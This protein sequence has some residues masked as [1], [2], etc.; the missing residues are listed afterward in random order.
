M[1][2]G[3]MFI[4]LKVP[5]LTRHSA[6]VSVRLS[7][8]LTL[9][10]IA[11]G[12]L[13]AVGPS[14]FEAV[15][16]PKKEEAV[17]ID[18]PRQYGERYKLKT[19]RSELR[20]ESIDPKKFLFAK[21]AFLEEKRDEAIR[22][23]RQQLDA[24][25]P[26]NRPNLLLSL[27]QLYAEKYMDLSYRETELYTE[28]LGEY[29]KQKEKDKKAKAPQLDNARSKRYLKDALGLFYSLEREHPQH[30]KIDE[31]LFFIGFVEIESGNGDK[32]SRYLERVVREFQRSRKYDEAVIYLADYYFDKSRFADALS[33]YRIL[34]GRRDSELQPYAFYKMAWCELNTNRASQALRN[35]RKLIDELDG[36]SDKGKFNLR[37]QAIKDLAVFFVE[38]DAV[39][40]A[41]EF[42]K[43]KEGE[44][45]A[46]ENLKLIADMLRSKARDTAAIKAYRLIL[47]ERPEHPEAP[48][49]ELGIYESLARMGRANDAVKALN[50][51]IAKYNPTSE[52]MSGYK[53]TAEEKK[54]V[55]DAIADEGKRAGFFYH[56]AAQK[57]KDKGLY[58]HALSLYA[59]LME[60]YPSHP[61]RKKIQFFRAE[62]LYA[63]SKWLEAAN[64][65]IEVSKTIPKDKLN[66]EA[67]YNALL[68]LDH[69]TAKSG[70]IERYKPEQQKDVD[71]SPQD[72]PEGE[73]RFIEVAQ[74]YLKEFP[75]GK[76]SL[77]VRYRIGAIH[78][79]YKHFE[80]ALKEFEALALQH[81]SDKVAPF[82]A[83]L[84][85][86]IYNMRKNYEG[87]ELAAEKYLKIGS[88]GDAKFKADMREVG[89]E[90]G[91]KKIEKLEANQEWDKAGDAYWR[92]YQ[93]NPKGELAEKSLYNAHVSYTKSQKKQRADEV[94]KVFL[95]QFPKSVHS[96]DFA[97]AAAKAAEERFDFQQA[98]QLFEKFH[99][100]HPKHKEARKALF[101]AALFAELLG[102]AKEAKDLYGQYLRSGT[103]P[104]EERQA[105]E[106]SL[107]AIHKKLKDLNEMEKMFRSLVRDAK[108]TKDKLGYLAELAKQFELAGQAKDRERLVREIASMYES[109]AESARKDF[110]PALEYVAEARFLA[111]RAEKA[112][113]EKIELRFPPQD[114]VYLLGRKQKALKNFAAKL[115][116]VIEVGVPLW[117][118]AALFDKSDAYRHFS[119]KYSE[120]QI[121]KKY[122]EAER[123][124]ADA[125]LKQIEKDLV[126]PL[127]VKGREFALSCLEK[128]REFHVASDYVRQCGMVASLETPTPSGNTPKAGHFSYRIPLKGFTTRWE[129]KAPEPKDV[130]NYLAYL[131][132]IDS[133]NRSQEV[134][135]RLTAFMAENPKDLRAQFIF[136]NHSWRTGNRE[137]ARFFYSKLEKEPEFEWRSL[138]LNQYG[139]I[140]LEE[141]RPVVAADWFEK[142]MESQPQ[143]APVFV[144]LGSM[145]LESG[146]YRDAEVLFLRATKMDSAWEDAAVGLGSAL[147]GQGK[148]QEAAETYAE[149]LSDNSDAL[150]AL[151]NHALILGNRLNQ[152]VKASQLMLQYLQKGGK[153]TVRAQKILGTW[154]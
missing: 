143:Y 92:A 105:I 36:A 67:L 32:G 14:S 64:A 33:K 28:R 7:T 68:A 88:L 154:R 116:K 60:H 15:S 27:G 137:M 113:Y 71:L 17:A 10:Q 146:N 107:L 101:N 52:W 18:V 45:K 120:V 118:V 130:D 135:K 122:S 96:A 59:S 145:Y 119:Q 58:R 23:M 61:E 80:E 42:Y 108:T 115:D 39:D 62:I 141:K 4:R 3:P 111:L 66:D 93:T 86:D 5:A 75:K 25:L 124:E 30:P 44:D 104:E 37:E 151:Y 43:D 133:V 72:I 26:G 121:P 74:L 131:A 31:V 65:Y 109:S 35:M 38:A 144:N 147:E 85:L 117:G 13:Y 140:A 16:L 20:Q 83:Y 6:L 79:K 40:E 8:V 103:I 57:G 102:N 110:G 136:A 128:A 91:F 76:R 153:D 150:Q 134:E 12:S 97:L 46:L 50:E 90:I 106:L 48:R 149:F 69:L 70:K 41:F 51:I 129:G 125:S 53:G 22:L 126:E 77:D 78:Y 81:P 84:T 94:T 142:A 100:N 82:C 127:K 95:T 139:T 24:K 98:Q 63:Q 9:S 148:F 49:I 112:R 2:W 11:I 55:S 114:L 89:N 132:S 47:S 99:A 56:A 123:K 21:E 34:A 19:T 73:Q 87:M 54:S 152:R 29:E 1:N 138:L